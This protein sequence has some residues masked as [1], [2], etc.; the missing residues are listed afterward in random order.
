MIE[1]RNMMASGSE[2]VK[3]HCHIAQLEVGGRATTAV[4]V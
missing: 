4:P 2:L 3:A 1:T